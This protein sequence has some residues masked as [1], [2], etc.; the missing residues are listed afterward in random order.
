MITINNYEKFE[1]LIL[2]RGV[3]W[4]KKYPMDMDFLLELNDEA[5]VFG[6]VKTAGTD[7]LTG[8]RIAI[9]RL[10]RRVKKGGAHAVGL[11][12][13]HNIRTPNPIP[14]KDCL[15]AKYYL[16]KKQDGWRWRE[17]S[18]TIYTRQAVELI[19]KTWGVRL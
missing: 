1:Q 3:E 7:I 10:C 17:P 14:L 15:L 2:F 18:K 4:G 6:E 9:E 11:L 12:V 13:T 5:F 8:Q 19:C 16:Y